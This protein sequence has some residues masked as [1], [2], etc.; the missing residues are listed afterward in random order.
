MNSTL[1]DKGDAEPASMS[2]KAPELLGGTPRLRS[3]QREQVEMLC[4]S[5]NQLLDEEHPVRLVWAAVGALDL[6]RWLVNIKAVEGT[7][8]R[9]ATDPRL[10]VAL[11]VYATTRGVGSARALAKLCGDQGE[12]PY[13]W[14]CGGVSLNYH[15][16]SDFRSENGEAWDELVTQIVAALMSEGLVTLQR[17]AQDGMRVEASA[18]TSS[19]RRRAT[20]EKCLQE[21]REQVDILK[22]LG[23]DDPTELSKR[24]KAARVVLPS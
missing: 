22:T 7:V 2:E 12:L 23:E 14:L 9:D 18:G 8:G 13:R 1:F 11:W 24:E 3:P 16:L 21:A 10:L 5:L 6:T 17:V 19:F 4:F 20:L 15:T